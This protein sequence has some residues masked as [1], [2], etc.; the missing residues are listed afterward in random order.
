[1]KTPYYSYKKVFN[2]VNLGFI[3]DY[4]TVKVNEINM[5]IENEEW[6]EVSFHINHQNIV[7]FIFNNNIND[8][9]DKQSLLI[10]NEIIKYDVTN[11]ELSEQSMT[12]NKDKYKIICSILNIT[13][14]LF[15]TEK[16]IFFLNGSLS[17]IISQKVS[18]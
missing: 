18:N 17:E 4:F 11:E 14:L 1:M 5:A 7:S 10:L 16:I 9:K 15:D 12:T 2:R 8:Y 13:R 6:K 3:F